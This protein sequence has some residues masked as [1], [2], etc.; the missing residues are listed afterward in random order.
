MDLDLGRI[1]S[2]PPDLP[3]NP[4]EL[5]SPLLPLPPV[6]LLGVGVA[7][8]PKEGFVVVEGGGAM[9]PIGIRLRMMAI[10]R[11]DAA[12][13]GPGGEGGAMVSVGKAGCRDGIGVE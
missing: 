1:V 10:F 13:T 12:S 7:L 6:E 2:P 4:L 9:L 5:L 8:M 11:S 3:L